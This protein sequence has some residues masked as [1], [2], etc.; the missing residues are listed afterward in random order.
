MI[1]P[2]WCPHCLSAH[3]LRR[4]RAPGLTCKHCGFFGHPTMFLMAKPQTEPEPKKFR[5]EK[6]G[7][8]EIGRGY[9]WRV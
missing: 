4:Y 1:K 2:C 9:N 3:V 6:A 7:R 8:I 5:G